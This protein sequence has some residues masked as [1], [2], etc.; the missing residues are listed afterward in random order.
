MIKI[1]KSV[2]FLIGQLVTKRKKG[3]QT[4]PDCVSHISVISVVPNDL[5]LFFCIQTCPFN[6]VSPYCVFFAPIREYHNVLWCQESNGVKFSRV[7][8]TLNDPFFI[9]ILIIL[10]ICF[11]LT[12]NL[13]N[14]ICL[15]YMKYWFSS[16]IIILVFEEIKQGYKV[17]YYF[18]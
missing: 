10:L 16:S 6:P 8:M 17:F 1:V 9:L 15:A 5:S 3:Q 13:L 7:L 11:I 2:S 4:T 14:I 18:L 12:N